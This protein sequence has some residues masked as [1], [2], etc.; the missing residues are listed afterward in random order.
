MIIADVEWDRF[1]MKVRP[2][3]PSPQLTELV[4]GY[5]ASGPEPAERLAHT[6][7]RLPA[8][9]QREHLLKIV[10]RQVALTLGTA[11]GTLDGRQSF[12]SLGFD[13]LTAV[14]LRN[15]LYTVTGLALPAAS[16]LDHP[17]P[18][19]LA[20]SLRSALLSG[21]AVGPEPVLAEIDRLDE[22]VAGL[23]LDEQGSAAVVA[24]LRELTRA[25]SP[26]P[27]GDSPSVELANAD[28]DSVLAFITSQ[29]GIG[30]EPE[31]E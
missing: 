16:V 21:S 15:R 28:A 24:R 6:L 13:S 30:S 4:S 22:L 31:A 8:D 17:T 20:Q 2:G 5:S 7:L 18:H 19:A 29:L 14:E 26:A 9:E 11:E 10:G 1:A 3:R 12:Q 23:P 27:M 25:L